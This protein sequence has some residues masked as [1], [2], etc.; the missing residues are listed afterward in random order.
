M[1]REEQWQRTLVQWLRV[2]EA[3][4]RLA[5]C[6][7]PNGTSLKGGAREGAK[8][9]AM[10]LRAGFPDILIFFHGKV[11]AAELK[12]D[13]D[14]IT[15]AGKTYQR[16]SQKDMAL[17]LES[18]GVTCEVWRNLDDA[19]TSLVANGVIWDSEHAVR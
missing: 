18:H 6:H 19:G 5:F 17:L 9:K 12:V 1:K 3:Q 13:A 14:P 10:G 4:R 7:V 16:Q 15:G 2:L 11:I 8:L